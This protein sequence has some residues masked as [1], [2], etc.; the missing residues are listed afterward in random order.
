MVADLPMLRRESGLTLIELMVVVVLIGVVIALVAPSFRSTIEMQRLRGVHDQ[1]VTD[2]QFARLEAARR[3]VP[4]HVRVMQESGGDSAC[5]ILFADTVR[6]GS[7]S[8]PCDCHLAAGSRCGAATTTEIKTVQLNTAHGIRLDHN[9][10]GRV[11]FDPATGGLLAVARDRRTT[12]DDVLQVDTY[13]DASR[14]LRTVVLHSGRPSTCLPSGSV[15][16]T[17]GLA[18]CP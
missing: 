6:A 2:L 17:G 13:L 1:L 5:Y 11:G 14:K 15:I 4:V 3:G 9:T 7:F 16:R 10:D 18:P 12:A 8:S